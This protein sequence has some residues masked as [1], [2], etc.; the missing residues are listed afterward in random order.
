LLPL[1]DI[2]GIN[3]A[4]L[5]SGLGR[6]QLLK[7]SFGPLDLGDESDPAIGSG[8]EGTAAIVANLDLVVSLDSSVAHLAGALG[9]PQWLLLPFVPDW[10]WQMTGETSPWYPKARLFR[11]QTHGDWASAVAAVVDRLKES[12]V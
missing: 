11:Q 12:Y 9:K 5:Q 7:L 6:E 10:R 1:L 2:P 3:L 8:F 4:S